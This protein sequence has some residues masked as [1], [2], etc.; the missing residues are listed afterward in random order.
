MDFRNAIGFPRQKVSSRE[1]DWE[2]RV[3]SLKGIINMPNQGVESNVRSSREDMQ[4]NYNLYNSII[5]EEDFEYVLDPYGIG[6]EFGGAPAKMEVFN[7]VR[8][9]IELLKGEE[10]NRP[11]KWYVRGVSG[12]VTNIRTMESRSLMLQYLQAEHQRNLGLNP[13]GD[14]MGPPDIQKYMNTEFMDPREVTANQLLRYFIRRDN[15]QSKFNQGWEHALIVAKEIYYCGIRDGHPSMRAVDPRYFY[16]DK[17]SNA[18]YIEDSYYAYEEMHLS[19]NTIIDIWGEDLSD[20]D[21]DRIESGSFNGQMI[22]AVNHLPGYVYDIPDLPPNG[23]NTERF[24]QGIPVYMAAWRSMEKYGVLEYDDVETMQRIKTMVDDTFK[25]TPDLKAANG[26]VKWYWRTQIWEGVQIG[27]D[28]YPYIRP[29]KYQ[30]GKLPYVGHTY[31]ATNSKP[32]SL[33]DLMKPHQYAYNVV[34]WKILA[35][36]AKASGS[37]MVMDMAQIPKSMGISTD[38]WIYYWDK[39][40]IA[41][42]N[43][44][45]ESPE[46]G[47]KSNF[48]QFRNIEMGVSQAFIQQQIMILEQIKSEI[49]MLTGVTPQRE[50][51]VQ[52]SES[53]TGVNTA[54]VQSSH[55][56]EPL[57]RKHSEV[58]KNVFTMLLE[59]AKVAYEED[60]TLIHYV[61]DDAY[62]ATLKVDGNTFPDSKYGVFVVDGSRDFVAKQKLEQLANVAL[63]QQTVRFS[64]IVKLIVSDSVSEFQTYLVNAEQRREQQTAELQK[65]QQESAERIE[66]SRREGEAELRANDNEQKELDRQAKI[67]EATIKALG[68]KDG[69]TDLNLN[70]VPDPV[71]Q[72]ELSLKA[73]QHQSDMVDKIEKRNSDMTLAKEKG[74]REEKKMQADVKRSQDEGQFK[75]M[76]MN[77]RTK[78]LQQDAKLTKEEQAQQNLQHRDQMLM[79]RKDLEIKLKT[80]ADKDKDRALKLKEMAH[81]EK[82]LLMKERIEKFKVK[83]KPKPAAKKK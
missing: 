4:I 57:F 80:L 44:M 24:G 73:M 41:W 30:L 55:I 43:S 31:N 79:Q 71:E 9:K 49:S 68:S 18:E 5:N 60:E 77:L 14:V 3:R 37:K 26:V 32:T 61:V 82:E 28:I 10:A 2:W 39:L 19:P 16:H 56:T 12:E 36:I 63:Q 13:T 74:E 62:M 78:Q 52:A 54:V 50:S 75:R 46:K 72:M 7:I 59:I 48:N 42:I 1:K 58:K 65:A 35:E 38:K 6:D 20:E 66:A 64:D 27:N 47:E 53:A 69:P 81:K 76:D 25:M 83:N 33:L 23:F 45:E 11:F 67:R 51:Q 29:L 22:G 8:S 15:M 21:I 17:D 34:W 70:G 40:N